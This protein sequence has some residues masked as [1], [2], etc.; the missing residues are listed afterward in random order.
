MKIFIRNYK[1]TRQGVHSQW[2]CLLGFCERCTHFPEKSIKNTAEDITNEPINT[3]TQPRK[4]HVKFTIILNQRRHKTWLHLLRWVDTRYTIGI[5]V[6]VFFDFILNWHKYIPL[7][8]RRVSFH[9][10]ESSKLLGS[11]EEM[12]LLKL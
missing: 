11:F 4:C 12:N 2:L 9:S 6:A 7:R 10:Q 8:S 3:Y 5:N 1:L